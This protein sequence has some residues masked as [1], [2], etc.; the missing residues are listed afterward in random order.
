[1][2]DLVLVQATPN[3]DRSTF[4]RLIDILE[5]TFANISTV[6]AQVK[7]SVYQLSASTAQAG[8]VGTAE[9]TLS[10][11]VMQPNVLAKDGY[12]LDIKAWGTFAANGDAK[13]IKLYFGNTVIYDTG[14]HA[15]NAGTW[16][17][18]ATVVRTDMAAEQA[19][20]SFASSNATT[21]SST[22]FV[23]ATESLASTVTIMVT[24]KGTS[25]NDVVENGLLINVFPRE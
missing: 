22:S 13:E 11:Y 25:N 18:N 1:M 5:N 8:S 14:S 15:A 21:P 20:T 19:I 12:N 24:G 10:S 7:K 3:Y 23:T 16:S 9:T 2:G 17:F 4:A 6:F